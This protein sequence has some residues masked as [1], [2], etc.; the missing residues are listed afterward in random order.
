MKDASWSLHFW[1]TIDVHHD[2]DEFKIR[3]NRKCAPRCSGKHFFE[4]GMFDLRFQCDFMKNDEN[5]K[6]APRCSGRHFFANFVIVSRGP[7][8]QKCASHSSGKHFFLKKC[9]VQSRCRRPD[10]RLA[11]GGRALAIRVFDSN[12]SETEGFQDD[13]LGLV[14]TRATARFMGY[15]R[16]RRPPLLGKRRTALDFWRFSKF[17]IFVKKID[18]GVFWEVTGRSGILEISVFLLFSWFQNLF[19]CFLFF[20]IFFGG[21]EI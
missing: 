1:C 3:E 16:F 6:C 5:R 13:L 4:G 10:R 2:C 7:E 8:N 20:F 15:R 18:F 21:L 12:I 11:A 19:F 9:M 14:A 17:R